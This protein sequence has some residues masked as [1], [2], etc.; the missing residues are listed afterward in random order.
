MKSGQ[1]RHRVIVEQNKPPSTDEYGTLSPPAWD[2]F[3][4]RWCS[5]EPLSGDE[6]IAAQHV[7][8]GVTHRVTMRF[9]DG[10]HPSMRL[11]DGDRIL[12]ISRVINVG[13]RNATQELFCREVV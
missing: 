9:L 2:T 4:E 5:I 8:A 10:L 6:L 3:E 1:L 12:N 7:Q 11:R 13:E